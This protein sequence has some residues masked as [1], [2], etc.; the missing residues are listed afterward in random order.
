MKKYIF[1]RNE[2]KWSEDFYKLIKTKLCLPSWFGENADALWDML[3]GFVETPCEIVFKN[4]DRKENDYNE[5][6]I[7]LILNC[8][9]DA[10][11]EYPAKFKIL[12]E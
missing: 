1:D 11:K 12:F 3:T 5:R 7:N 10:E 6:N 4:F 2:F 9:K 8:F